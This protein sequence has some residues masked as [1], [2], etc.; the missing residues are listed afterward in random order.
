MVGTVASVNRPQRIRLVEAFHSIFYSPVVV[1]VLGGYLAAEGLEPTLTTAEQAS[2]IADVLLEGRADVAISG[3]VRSFDL[4]NRGGPHLI[5]F[6]A[7]NDRNGFFLLSRTPRTRF[8]W[9]D[10]VGRT[11]L[12]YSGAPTPWLCMQAVLRRHGIDP[13]RVNSVRHLAARDAVVAFRAGDADFLEHG[14]PLVDELVRDGVGH[15]VASMGEATGPLAFSSCMT[16]PDMLVHGRDLLL[17][18]VRGLARAQ[19]WMRDARAAE[20]AEAIAPA[21]PDITAD[22]RLRAVERYARQSTWASHPAITPEGFEALEDI[23][24]AGGFIAGRHRFEDLVDTS[25]VEQAT[26][27]H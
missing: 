19:R 5:H 10:L 24:L 17:R 15:L 9:S 14:P 23:L 13:T 20:I 27:G 18:F 11:V 2:S 4:V 1:S 12:S 22:I 3:L 7:I 8:A 16:T 25:F 6:A 21:F 26:G